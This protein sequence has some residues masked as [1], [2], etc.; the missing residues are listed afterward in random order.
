MKGLQA[1][2]RAKWALIKGLF[3]KPPSKKFGKKDLNPKKIMNTIL[4]ILIT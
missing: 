3:P 4:W 2:S 1:V